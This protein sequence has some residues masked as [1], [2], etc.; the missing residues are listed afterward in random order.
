M[1][2]IGPTHSSQFMEQHNSGIT[3]LK[4]GICAPY[5]FLKLPENQITTNFSY[6]TSSNFVTISHINYWDQLNSRKNIWKF[7]NGPLC[8]NKSGPFPLLNI[9]VYW[10]SSN[11]EACSK[12]LSQKLGNNIDSGGRGIGLRIYVRYCSFL[13]NHQR[14]Q[15]QNITWNWGIFP[16]LGR[17]TQS[18]LFDW[19]LAHIS[20][21]RC[22]SCIFT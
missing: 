10:Q 8:R 4:H 11:I 2:L 19:K 14:Y 12:K 18:C 20:S 17:K 22:W 13:W 15:N 7:W 1:R 5:V 9:A 3:T 21:W 16:N 6:L